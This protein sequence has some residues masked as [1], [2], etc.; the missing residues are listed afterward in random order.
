MKIGIALLVCGNLFI[1]AVDITNANCV[2]DL[3]K[4]RDEYLPIFVKYEN[5]QQS[6]WQPSSRREITIPFLATISFSC[7]R[8]RFEKLPDEEWVTGW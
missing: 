4:F 2:I 7:S 5:G 1:A 3:T 6:V 8:V